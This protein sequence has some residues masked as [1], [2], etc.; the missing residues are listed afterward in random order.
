MRKTNVQSQE[1]AGGFTMIRILRR[2]R[3]DRSIVRVAGQRPV[4]GPDLVRLRVASDPRGWLF[5]EV[6]LTGVV[7]VVE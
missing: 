1:E 6:L 4:L 2:A 7:N 3:L 5:E